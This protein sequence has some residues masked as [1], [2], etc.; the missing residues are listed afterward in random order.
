MLLFFISS[1]HL[2]DVVKEDG[3]EKHADKAI[4]SRN[5]VFGSARDGGI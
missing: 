3:K 5:P 1:G 4:A 2:D